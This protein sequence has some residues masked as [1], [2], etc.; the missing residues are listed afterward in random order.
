[1]SLS[2]LLL[3]AAGGALGSVLRY[4]VSLL[5]V[6]WFGAG[7]PWGT[8]A[9]NVL[10]SAAIGVLAGLGV[11]GM[12]WLTS[13]ACARWDGCCGNRA[14]RPPCSRWRCRTRSSS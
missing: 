11:Q 7:F 4:L 12:L 2:A 3:V 9:V 6:A 14:A 10:G 1:M 13:P 8:L 5:A